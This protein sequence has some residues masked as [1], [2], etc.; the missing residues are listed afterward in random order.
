[1]FRRAL[2]IANPGSSGANADEL[3]GALDRYAGGMEHR[4]RWLTEGEEAETVARDELR[5]GFDLA[6]AA[7]GDGTVSAVARV[8]SE[9][10]IPL[11]IAPMGTANMLAQQLHIP[12]SVDGALELLERGAVVR[13][14][15]ALEIDGRL[16]FLNASIGVSARAVHDLPPT[17]KRLFGLSAYV[18]MGIASSFTF[19]PVPC[20]VSIDG[21]ARRLRILD[22]SIINA[23]FQARGQVPGF[24]RV[25]PDDGHLDVLTVWAPSASE[26]LAHLWRAFFLWR[27]VNPNVKWS[28]AEREVSIESVKPTPVQADGDIVG[29]T[30]VTVRL[31]RGAVGVLVPAGSVPGRML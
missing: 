19:T 17:G 8:A 16:Y 24:P 2:V 9:L 15:D 22:V 29:E 18:W 3:Q 23:G 20:T 28:I 11:A 6:V 4:V 25:Q 1:M 7:G 12:G 31:V 27:K 21:N 30:P 14:I 26:Y 5:H 10:G 13:R